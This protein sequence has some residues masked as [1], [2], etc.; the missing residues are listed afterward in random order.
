MKDVL[1][2]GRS[3]QPPETSEDL[4]EVGDLRLAIRVENVVAFPKEAL[5]RRGKSWAALV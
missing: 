2:T 3:C 5:L 1:Q 4:K